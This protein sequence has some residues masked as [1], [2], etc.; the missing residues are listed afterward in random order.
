MLLCG[1]LWRIFMDITKNIQAITTARTQLQRV[2]SFK[3][4]KRTYFVRTAVLFGAILPGAFLFLNNKFTVTKLDAMVPKGEFPT[5]MAEW[6]KLGH[7]I[8][9]VNCIPDNMS[10]LYHKADI[11]YQPVFLE[12]YEGCINGKV[13]FYSPH[14]H[15]GVCNLTTRLS[16]A[17]KLTQ[18]K[19]HLQLHQYSYL[20]LYFVI[21]SFYLRRVFS[22]DRLTK[23]METLLVE[24]NSELETVLKHKLDTQE[25][26]ILMDAAAT[27]LTGFVNLSSAGEYALEVHE[28]H[29]QTL[30]ERLDH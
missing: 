11:D 18:F 2:D 9:E 24:L 13:N 30:M 4:H 15:H 27:P 23:K 1:K 5:C 20:I 14:L 12:K 29:Q 8:G 10:D 19:Y 7:Q 25:M 26:N 21:L 17:V 3:K 28:K 16:P 22:D 6:A